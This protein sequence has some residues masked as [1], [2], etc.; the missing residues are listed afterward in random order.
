MKHCS[1]STLAIFDWLHYWTQFFGHGEGG[2]EDE[3]EPIS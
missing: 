3:I 1:I 2:L